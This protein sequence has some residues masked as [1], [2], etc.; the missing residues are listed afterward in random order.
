M[1]SISLFSLLAYHIYLISKNRSTLGKYGQNTK[2]YYLFTHLIFF[3]SETFRPPKFA[4]GCDKNGFNLGCC[5][6]IQEVFGKELILWPL[7]I[8]TW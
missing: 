7:P 5:R 2:K 1:F 4:H 6:N 3:F 8:H